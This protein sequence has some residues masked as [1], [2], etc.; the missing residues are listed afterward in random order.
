[1]AVEIKATIQRGLAEISYWE[2]RILEVAGYTRERAIS[3]LVVA[4]KVN[5]KITSI[6][7]FIRSLED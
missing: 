3:E 5:E 7:K 1:M 6:R 2:R 4:L